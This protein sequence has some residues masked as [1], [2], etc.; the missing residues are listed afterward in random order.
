V[1]RP[2]ARRRPTP[3]RELLRLNL[4]GGS[5]DE[6]ADAVHRLLGQTSLSHEE[7][8]Q[9]LCGAAVVEALRP[10]WT[11]S[12]TPQEAHEALRRDDP[13]IADAIE[14]LAPMLLGRAEAKETASLALAEVEA[15]L[16]AR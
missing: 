12:R 5:A 1:Q 16:R 11:G 9:V 10:Y 2:T 13:E 7:R 4:G 8:V 6:V 3:K 14:A 15:L